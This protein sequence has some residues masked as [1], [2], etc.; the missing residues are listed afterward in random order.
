MTFA[1]RDQ[2][3]H[4]VERI[5]RRSRRDEAAVARDALEL[6]RA[7]PSNGADQADRHQHVGYYL[8]DEGLPELERI[9]GYR[10]HAGLRLYRWALR[11]PNVVFVGGVLAGTL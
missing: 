4:V 8:V 11:H 6:A 1:T 10:P 2:Y 9:T 5:A 3:R 7:A